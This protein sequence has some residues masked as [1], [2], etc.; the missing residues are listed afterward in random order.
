MNHK[1]PF[2]PLNPPEKIEQRRVDA[3]HRAL[4]W[5]ETI[6]TG[7]LWKPIFVGNNVSLQRTI[8]GQ[9]I[10]IFPLEAAYVDLGMKSRFA[11]D[12]LPIDLNNF[13]CLCSLDAFST[14][15]FTYRYDRQHDVTPG[16]H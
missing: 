7:T 15:S 2:G 13:E 1:T 5:C 9:T 10:E 4:R 11:A 14:T 8:N 3:V 6:L 12:H 16:S